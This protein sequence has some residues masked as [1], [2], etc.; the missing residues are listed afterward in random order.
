[1]QSN[2]YVAEQYRHATN[3]EARMGLHERFSTNHY[4]WMRWVFDQLDL[5]A[6]AQILEVGC[7]TGQLWLENKERIPLDWSITLLD[8]SAGMLAKT[9]ANLA[10]VAHAFRL[11]CCDVQTLPFADHSFDAVVANHMLY[12]VADLPR[13]LGE[14]ARVLKPGSKLI[15]ATNGGNHMRQMRELLHIFDPQFPLHRIELSF[16]LENG[17]D[18][19]AAH[20]ARVELRRFE[21]GL[22]VTEAQPLIDYTLSMFEI[23]GERRTEFAEFVEQQLADHDGVLHIHKDT[24]LFIAHKS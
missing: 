12:H 13:G 14:I 23:P 4:P 1:M 8:Q 6:T 2:L 17:A 19:L 22:A 18:W 24:G 15:A 5:P 11:E 7:G 10:Q 21:G 20:F 9:R 16:T 3:L